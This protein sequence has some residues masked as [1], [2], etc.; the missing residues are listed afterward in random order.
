MASGRIGRRPNG[1]SPWRSPDDQDPDPI[2]VRRPWRRRGLASAL[3]GRALL[4]L[5]DND[6]TSAQ[7]DVDSENA[8]QAF[9]LY[10]R[11]GFEADREA[12]EWLK[13]LP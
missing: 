12:C 10:E 5:R 13:P 11:Q 6:M 9:T 2:W 7:L 3:L 1:T 4:V 8:N